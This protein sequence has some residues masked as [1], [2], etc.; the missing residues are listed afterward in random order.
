[1][2]PKALA[3]AVGAAIAAAVAT[4]QLPLTPDAIPSDVVIERPRNPEH[5]DYATNVAMRLAK[6]AGMPRGRSPPRLPTR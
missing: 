6:P 1:M 2:T 4:G 5:G 3:E